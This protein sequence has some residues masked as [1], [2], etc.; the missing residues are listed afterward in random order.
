MVKSSKGHTKCI[1][2]GALLHTVRIRPYFHWHFYLPLITCDCMYHNSSTALLAGRHIPPVIRQELFPVGM[3]ASASTAINILS[4]HT[5]SLSPISSPIAMETGQGW[6]P[7]LRRRCETCTK[8]G[9]GI[10]F[11]G[12]TTRA[13][14]PQLL[15]V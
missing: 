15:L 4:Y 7:L 2:G 10:C 9:E 5:L 6:T 1:E 12:L 14:W 8:R 11:Q 3:E 13:N